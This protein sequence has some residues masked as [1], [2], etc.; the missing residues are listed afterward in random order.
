MS[1]LHGHLTTDH[2]LK[3]GG[4]MQYGLFLKGIGMSLEDSMKFWRSQFL[5]KM[6]GEKVT[7]KQIIKIY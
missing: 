5:H 3:H 6:D 7:N 4:R 1:S 2:H